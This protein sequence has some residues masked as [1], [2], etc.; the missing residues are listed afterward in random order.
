VRG[1]A[2][3]GTVIAG[4]ATVYVIALLL[5]MSDPSWAY[6]ARGIVHLGELAIVV[7]LL[8]TGAAAGALGRI[9]GVLAGIGLVAMAV[10]EVITDSASELATI[11]FQVGPV[12]VGVGM[13]GV[14]IPVLRSWTGW[15]RFTPLVLG[16]GVFV[17]LLPLVIVSGGPPAPLGLVGILV[18]EVLWVAVGVAALT[19]LP[20]RAPA[21]A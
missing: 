13:I 9:G 10:A 1:P 17:V 3:V 12:L 2:V 6:L 16:I 11:L 20:A 7:A 4:V 15:R 21:A 18:W 19:A 5:G 8:A 14:G